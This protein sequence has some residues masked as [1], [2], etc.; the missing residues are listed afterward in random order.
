[1]GLLNHFFGSAES[2]AREIGLDDE[3][4]LNIWKHYVET[5][6]EKRRITARLGP[7][8]SLQS[9]LEELSRLLKLELVDISNEEKEE[10]ELISDLE[11]MEHSQK[12]KQVHK[13]EQCLGYSETK[14]EYVYELLRQLYSILK[15]EMH[16]VKSL[17][18]RSEDTQV[19]ISHMKLQFELEEEIIKKIEGIETFQG[20]FV[21]LIKGEHI[22]K[23]MDSGEKR[24]LEKMQNRAGRIFSNE[25]TK[26][27]TYEWMIA[28]FNAIDDKV[29]ESVANGIFPGYNPDIDF[30]FVNRPDFI[31]LAR[32]TIQNLEKKRI[33]ERMINV[34]VYL[35]REWYNHERD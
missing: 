14:Y 3:Y 5:I 27:A 20:L 32:N 24:L 2:I 33:S 35:F 18:M 12:I 10:S 9:N 31:D 25:I 6:S 17:L 29:H 22:I 7:D 21:A 8:S 28:V 15:S 16:I 11:A 1:M 19:S 34:F 13:L 30:E 23:S 4:I 26:E